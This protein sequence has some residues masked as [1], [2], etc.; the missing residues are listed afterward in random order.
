MEALPGP[1]RRYVVRRDS[2]SNPVLR[3]TNNQGQVVCHVV[4]HDSTQPYIVITGTI[5]RRPG[6]QMG[7][8]DFPPTVRRINATVN[9]VRFDMN[10]ATPSS[11]HY[12]FQSRV[13]E[14]RLTWDTVG[15]TMVLREDNEDEVARVAMSDWALRKQITIDILGDW[16]NFHGP[17][18]AAEVFVSAIAMFGMRRRQDM[19]DG[20]EARRPTISDR[21]NARRRNVRD[22]EEARGQHFSYRGE[23]ACLGF[24]LI[25][26]VGLL[27]SYSVFWFW[28]AVW[29]YFQP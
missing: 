11:R 6:H 13:I 24:C 20:A 19:S 15:M 22:G 12:C 17:G 18:A 7:R 1:S 29:G 14:R 23:A 8:V 16:A 10:P 2:P 25:L 27:L 21:E 4:S 28:R 5:P 26:L 9:G 3:A